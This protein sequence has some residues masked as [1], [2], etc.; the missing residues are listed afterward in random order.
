MSLTSYQ[1]APPRNLALPN[2]G[3]G[4][5]RTHNP[6]IRSLMLYPVEL[7]PQIGK[8]E[9]VYH[10]PSGRARGYLQF[11]G[12]A[13]RGIRSA[14]RSGAMNGSATSIP[15]GIVGLLAPWKSLP[16][17]FSS[18]SREAILVNSMFSSGRFAW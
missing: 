14:S 7:Q 16:A 11:F 3:A 9:I 1:A 6:Q 17:D 13:Q 2:G 18:P 12:A 10:I 4:G 8:R 5:S 15:S